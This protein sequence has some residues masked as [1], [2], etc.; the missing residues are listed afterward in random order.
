MD[1]LRPLAAT[2]ISS[3][4]DAMALQ[5]TCLDKRTPTVYDAVAIPPITVEQYLS[6]IL[7]I[8][9]ASVDILIS[10]LVHIDSLVTSGEV[11]AITPYNVHR[12][13]ATSLLVTSKFASDVHY[14]NR[15]WS[16]ISG[17]ELAEVNRLEET[18]L[19]S[20]GFQLMVKE[21]VYRVYES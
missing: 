12:L 20:L 11:P 18:F 14:N 8:S 17:T 15:A 7:S 2:C 1:N 5:G 6:R 3:L 9:G 16:F 10:A 21:T 19:D 13:L 4:L